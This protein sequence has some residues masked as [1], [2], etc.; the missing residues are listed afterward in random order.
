MRAAAYARFSTDKQTDN[1]IAYQ[2]N[3]IQEYCSKN[4][5]QI[6]SFFSD[7]AESGTNMDRQGFIDMVAAAARH[8]FDAVVIYDISRGSRDVG[9]W[10]NF[11]KHMLR[12]GVQVISATQQLGDIMNPSDFLVELISVGLGQHAV[13]DTRQKSIAGVAEKAKQ[14]LFLGGVPPLGYDVINNIY[15]INE[16]EAETVRTIFEMYGNGYSFGDIL[17]AIRDKRGKRGQPFGKNSLSSILRN[18]RYIGVYS[19]NKRK[20]KLMRRWAGGGLNPNGIRIEDSMPQIVPI[21]VWERVKERMN[22]NKRNATS[23][24][25]REYLLSGLIECAECGA[26]YVG[27]TSRNKKG[28][29]TRYYVCGNK[30]RTHTCKSK[31][32]NADELETYVVQQLK[33]YLL[34]LDFEETAQTIADSVNNATQDL[35]AEKKELSEIDT[36]ITNGIRAVLS[37]MRVPELDDEI[38]RLRIRKSE[39]E[40]IIAHAESTGGQKVDPAKIVELFRESVEKFGTE[41]MRETI[42]LYITKIYANIDGSITVNVGVHLNGCGGRI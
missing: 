19:W 27:H 15:V 24:A 17:Y 26:A 40:D 3:K 5:I 14:G 4:D 9:D 20:T 29:E 31:N 13:L 16:P 33:G 10:F 1:S 2:F 42:K 25:K 7:E 36:K 18:E 37:G 21:D 12:L 22:D 38:D 6:V 32:I 30:Y 11:R 34:G 28:Y 8:E 35:S 23:K 41:D 39:L